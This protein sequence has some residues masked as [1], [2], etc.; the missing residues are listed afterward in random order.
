[1]VPY[2]IAGY[3]GSGASAL[4]DHSP[5]RSPTRTLPISPMPLHTILPFTD[6][7]I[8]YEMSLLTPVNTKNCV[9]SRGVIEGLRTVSGKGDFQGVV[10]IHGVGLSTLGGASLRM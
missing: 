7:N 1:M 2:L 3:L 10:C 4:R 5:G 8:R 6:R 9:L